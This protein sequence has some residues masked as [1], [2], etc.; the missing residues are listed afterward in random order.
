MRTKLIFLASLLLFF[1]CFCLLLISCG[2]ATSPGTSPP[3]L[4]RLDIT[5]TTIKTQFPPKML[6]NHSYEVKVFLL[7]TANGENISNILI[8]KATVVASNPTPVGTPHTA[9]LNA[10]G[11]G[12]TPY[13]TANLYGGTFTIQAISPAEQ[14]LQQSIIEWDWNITPQDTG[15]QVLNVDVVLQ[16]KSTLSSTSTLPPPTYSIGNPSMLVTVNDP[17]FSLGSLDIGA[18]LNAAIPILLVSIIGFFSSLLWKQYTKRNRKKQR[19]AA[20][21]KTSTPAPKP[22]EAS[23]NAT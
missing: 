21:N 8:E 5:Q 17:P 13:A 4:A 6:K 20:R 3:S 11:P 1:T 23:G 19:I 7:S 12:Y 2:G 15:Q 16:W 10:F 14:S 18:I 22:P 9:L